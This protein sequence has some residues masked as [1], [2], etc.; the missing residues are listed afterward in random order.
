MKITIEGSFGDRD[1]R[2]PT[3]FIDNFDDESDIFQ[4]FEEL[5]IPALV[6]VGYAKDSVEEA[7]R[8]FGG[9][10]RCTDV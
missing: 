9:E 1:L 6:G 8:E 2:H 5:V 7:C 3:V 4:M 10:D